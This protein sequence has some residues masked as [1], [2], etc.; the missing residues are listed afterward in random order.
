MES[1]HGKRNKVFG[2]K[3]MRK[4]VNEKRDRGKKLKRKKIEISK[5]RESLIEFLSMKCILEDKR[6]SSKQKKWQL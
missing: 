5:V 3:K 2:G 4:K 1:S 6:N